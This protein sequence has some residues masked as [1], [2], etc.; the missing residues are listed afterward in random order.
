MPPPREQGGILIDA[1]RE[2]L[3]EVLEEQRRAW[4]RERELIESQARTAIAELRAEIVTLSNQI[5][6]A[7]DVRLTG[8]R[9][10]VNGA[11][12]VD[13]AR[14]ETGPQGE[15]GERGEPGLPGAEGEQGERGPQG[16][17]GEQGEPGLPGFPGQRGERGEQ[18]PQG[19]RGERGE[20]G[21][22]GEAGPQGKQGLPGERGAIG[23][24]GLPGADG[25]RGAIGLQGEPGL[26]GERGE[27][28]LQ[29]ERGER[30]AIGPIGEPGPQGERGEQGP[31]GERGE[32][33]P[34]GEPG[35]LPPV[36]R[37]EPDRVYYAGEVVTF[38]GCCFQAV[39]DTGRAP[40]QFHGDD[41]ICLAA[42]GHPGRDARTPKPRGTFEAGT[43]YQALDI[44][45]LNG[46]SFIALCD[47]PGPCPGADWQLLTRQGARGIAGQRGER[48]EPGADGQPGAPGQAGRNGQAAPKLS[49]WLIDSKN[50][51]AVPVWSDG[52]RG[53]AIELRALFKQFQDETT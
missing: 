13:G 41:W 47:A 20:Q 40:D 16:L 31:Q 34:Q 49:N 7:V 22:F 43:I 27:Q 52:S 26:S 8:L 46:G 44:V 2:A 17:Q 15:R 33:G 51:S 25:E 28:G 19:E 3:A 29:G 18:G 6:T 50:Y 36:K 37:Y 35:R 5:R 30:G 23:P 42:A 1:W 45:A 38:D 14:G 39:K 11:P 53:P 48:G 9:D 4:E 24:I 32:Q 12:G 10:G 21:D